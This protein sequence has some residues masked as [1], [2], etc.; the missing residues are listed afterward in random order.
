MIIASIFL[1]LFCLRVYIYVLSNT[2]NSNHIFLND[3]TKVFEISFLFINENK[4]LLN[5]ISSRCVALPT[6]SFK[7]DA[8]YFFLVR[9][10]IYLSTGEKDDGLLELGK[11]QVSKKFLIRSN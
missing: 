8:Q 4:K 10:G 6:A 1:L 7:S 5:N 11:Q 9:H 3:V 2:Y